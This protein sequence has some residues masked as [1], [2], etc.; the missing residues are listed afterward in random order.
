LIAVEWIEKVHCDHIIF[1]VIEAE[2][3][4]KRPVKKKAGE[5]GRKK[6]GRTISLLATIKHW[7]TVMSVPL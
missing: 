7:T 2:T 3:K 4:P 1:V 5:G 6:K